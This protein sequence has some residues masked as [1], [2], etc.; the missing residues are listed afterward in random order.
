[1]DK[2]GTQYQNIR[3]KRED[4][5]KL[6]W[7]VEKRISLVR[8]YGNSTKISNGNIRERPIFMKIRIEIKIRRK[9]E[10]MKGWLQFFED[11][12][13]IQIIRNSILSW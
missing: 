6:D 7:K 2:Y 3:E 12:L 9:I 13:N 8:K 5:M 11:I 10:I 1:M 4:K